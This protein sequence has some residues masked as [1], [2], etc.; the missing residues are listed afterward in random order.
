MYEGEDDS[1]VGVVW[2][3]CRDRPFVR[4]P[5]NHLNSIDSRTTRSREIY[6]RRA[7]LLSSTIRWSNAIARKL[8]SSYY[9]SLSVFLIL[10]KNHTHVLRVRRIQARLRQQRRRIAS[11]WPPGAAFKILASNDAAVPLCHSLPP[12][13]S[14]RAS[15]LRFFRSSPID[16]RSI[17]R[18]QSCC[19]TLRLDI[20]TRS[21]FRVAPK[22]GVHRRV[23]IA[24]A[25]LLVL[26]TGTG[27]VNRANRVNG[28]YTSRD[29]IAHIQASPLDRAKLV[30]HHPDNGNDQERT[31][32]T[33]ACS[34]DQRWSTTTWPVRQVA[35]KRANVL[36]SRQGWRRLRART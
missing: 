8:C 31:M 7:S 11:G 13:G 2:R 23:T 6:A 34:R 22:P 24:S 14:L 1:S 26:H 9:V 15:L 25:A 10:K 28:S 35:W 16:G 20:D 30:V 33:R 19:Y 5:R 36:S 32:A 27:A 4:S 3:E 18:A 12:R 29:T 21:K 17:V